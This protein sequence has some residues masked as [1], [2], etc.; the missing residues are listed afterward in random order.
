[1]I[2]QFLVIVGITVLVALSPGPDMVIVMRNTIVG[3]RG[4]GLQTS[5]GILTGNLV[6]ISYCVV[7]IGWLISQSIVAFSILKYAGAAYLT[8]L[9]IMSFRSNGTSL[10][11][12]DAPGKTPNK[13]WFLQGFINNVLNPKGALFFLGVFTMVITP[14]TSVGVTLLLIGVMMFICASFWLFFVYSLDHPAIRQFINRFQ[15]VTSKIFGTLLVALGL[16]V[17]LLDR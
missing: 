8:Y 2:D 12:N 1:M 14:G 15:H 6:H 9:G 17:A 4:A 7:G 5:I 10:D 11:V 3:G 16:R 13:T